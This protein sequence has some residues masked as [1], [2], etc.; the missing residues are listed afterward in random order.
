VSASRLS[1]VPSGEVLL[2]LFAALAVV[3][4]LIAVPPVRRLLRRRLEPLARQSLPQLLAVATEPRRLLTG[5]GGILLQNAGYV[6]ALDASLR[7]FDTSLALPTVIGVYLVSSAVGS[8]APTPGG[9]GAVE[10]ALVGGLTATGVP[11]SAALAAVLAFRTVTFWLPAPV[12]WVAF[13]NLQRRR[14]I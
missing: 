4:I 9:L 11:V 7:A 6:L 14:F 13:V 8:V 1:L 2:V 5:L 10:A 12:G 3:G